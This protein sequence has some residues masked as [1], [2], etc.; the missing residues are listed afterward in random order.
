MALRWKRR[1]RNIAFAFLGLLVLLALAGASY[2]TVATSVDAH[3]LP[4]P[5]RLV[6]IGG[7]RLQLNCIGKG[8][9][10]VIL[11]SGL[12]D[13]LLIQWERVQPEIAKFS[14]V[15]SYGRAGYGG[16]DSGP[17]PRT[18]AQ[19]AEELHALLQEAGEKPPYLLVGSSFGGYNVR[20]FNGLYPDLVAGIVLVDSTQED[21]NPSDPATGYQAAQTHRLVYALMAGGLAI[22]ML[23]WL[24]KVRVLAALGFTQ[25][26]PLIDTLFTGLLVMGGA[27]RTE[28]MLQKLGAGSAAGPAPAATPVE[29]TGHLRIEDSGK[30]EKPG[31]E[32][33]GAAG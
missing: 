32:V 20:V 27:D 33:R 25:V 12:G 5:G 26:D 17:M 2:Q 6:D 10:T 13:V 28:T 29:I 16:S 4:E 19:I 8:S 9:P 24:G 23:S 11:E 1:F 21:Q 15:C 14:R 18:S 30:G 31:F 3:R 7:F 22:V